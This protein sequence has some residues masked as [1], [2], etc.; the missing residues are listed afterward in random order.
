VAAV[1]ADIDALKGLHGALARYRHAQRDVAARAQDQVRATRAALEEKASRLRGQLELCQSEYAGCRERAAQADPEDLPV[2][3]SGYA[4]A[5]AQ[6]AER[7]EQLQLW[8]QRV[9]AEVSEFAGIAGRFDALLAD[10]LPRLEEHL[11][12]IIA[13]LE[14]ARRVQAPS[15]LTLRGAIH[16]HAAGA[17]RRPASAAAR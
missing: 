17:G 11:A 16:D 13:T 12:A 14:A 3:C 5:V 7:L 1:H 6:N 15:S 4:R 9:E 2:D 10:D 8:Q